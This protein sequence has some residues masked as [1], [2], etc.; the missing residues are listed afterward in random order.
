MRK[1]IIR[2]PLTRL[3]LI[4]AALLLKWIMPRGPRRDPI[5]AQGLWTSQLSPWI[6]P[7]RR[8]ITARY[9]PMAD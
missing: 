5:T 4:W 6:T 2:Y 9:R 8:L 3:V 7:V 1:P